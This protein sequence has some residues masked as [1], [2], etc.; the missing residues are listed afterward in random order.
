MFDSH[1]VEGETP[2]FKGSAL[3][4]IAETE[5]EVKEVIWGDVYTRTGV[6]DVDAAQI[7]PF[8]SAV[9]VAV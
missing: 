7:I 4:C 6:W 9:R 3:I 5:E 2:S 1:P 8:K